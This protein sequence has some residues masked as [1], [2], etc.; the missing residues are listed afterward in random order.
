MCLRRYLRGTVNN[1]LYML[2]SGMMGWMSLM[3]DTTAWSEQQRNIA[4]HA[5]ALYKSELRPLIRDGITSDE[6]RHSFRLAGLRDDAR[7][8][9]QFEDGTSLDEVMTGQQLRLK[10]ISIHLQYPL[11][12]ELIFVRSAVGIL[13]K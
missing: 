12:S 8:D 11:N 10:G 7:Y 9:L 13:Q 2:R 4:R 3:L 6:P 1:F 5:F